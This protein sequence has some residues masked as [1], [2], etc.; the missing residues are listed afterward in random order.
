MH[1]PNNHSHSWMATRRGVYG[2]THTHKMFIH[3]ISFGPC[4][5]VVEL[6]HEMALRV[7]CSASGRP[8]CAHMS[9]CTHA[10]THL[11]W[12]R[13][14]RQ[15][16]FCERVRSDADIR[17]AYYLVVRVAYNNPSGNRADRFITRHR[18]RRLRGTLGHS[19]NVRGRSDKRTLEGTYANACVHIRRPFV[20]WS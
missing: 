18:T 10:S 17:V 6:G 7:R 2:D 1:L 12:L 3:T 15:H 14:R 11:L 4:T 13:I 5:H 16:T 8:C 20:E 19:W 9:Q